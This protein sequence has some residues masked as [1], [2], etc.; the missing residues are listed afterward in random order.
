MDSFHS[1]SGTRPQMSQ[2]DNR[3]GSEGVGDINAS[4][5]TFLFK[6]H[7]GHTESEGIWLTR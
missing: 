2:C 1:G 7:I 5:V 4:R 6:C 3:Y